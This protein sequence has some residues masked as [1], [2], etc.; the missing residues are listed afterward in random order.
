MI[1]IGLIGSQRKYNKYAESLP[2]TGSIPKSN[3]FVLVMGPKNIP[4]SL[5]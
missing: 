3:Q 4:E 5:N 2:V 1:E